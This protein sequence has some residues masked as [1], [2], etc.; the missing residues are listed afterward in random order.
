MYIA[1]WYKLP[2]GAMASALSKARWKQVSIFMCIRMIDLF[3]CESWVGFYFPDSSI[4]MGLHVCFGYR[5][6]VFA[7]IS[8]YVRLLWLRIHLPTH[9]VSGV[10]SILV[11]FSSFDCKPVSTAFYQEGFGATQA[12]HELAKYRPSFI[13]IFVCRIGEI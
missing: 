13:P 5:R 11:F 10:F 1:I 2:P 9:Y 3:C 12:L 6:V 8:M 7:F 4:S